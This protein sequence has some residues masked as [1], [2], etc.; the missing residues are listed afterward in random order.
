MYRRRLKGSRKL[1][2]MR[3]AKE[4]KRLAQEPREPMPAL[5]ELRRRVTVEDFD[6]GHVVHVLELYRTNR[7]DC[8]RA[9]ADGK[10]WK[11]RIGWARALAGLRK[12]FVRL[13]AAG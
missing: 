2:A 10:L 13:H 5:P 12:S 9:F 11:A 4:R 7:I 8:Y 6:H 1:A 3:A